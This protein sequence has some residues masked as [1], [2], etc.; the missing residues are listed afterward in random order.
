[1]T[2]AAN[3]GAVELTAR[4]ACFRDEYLIDM[5]AT[6]AALRAGFAKST[7]EK[8]APLWV[9]KSRESCPANMRH[10]WDAVNEAIQERSQRT[11]VAA[12][13]VIN[14]LVRMGFADIRQL[15][16][17]GG[18]LRS[19]HDLPDDLAAAIQSIKVVTKTIP[20]Q[21]DDEAEIEYV[22][23]VKLVDKVKPIE[24]IGK[25]LKMFVDRVE[26]DVS[27]RMADQIVAARKRARQARDE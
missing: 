9:G 12:D 23:E 17:P 25:H 7:A 13:D 6:K 20:G 27:D 5:N 2:K 11:Q 4:Q 10:V 14:Q 8:K 19:V 24:L 18:Q 15:F 22:H 26:H 3:K 21:G 16:T 1:M